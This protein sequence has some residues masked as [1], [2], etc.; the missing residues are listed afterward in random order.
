MKIQLK[1]ILGVP[2]DVYAELGLVSVSL[3]WGSPPKSKFRRV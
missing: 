3:H 1:D 2:N